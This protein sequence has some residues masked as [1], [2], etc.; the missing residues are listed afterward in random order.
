LE[1]YAKTITANKIEAQ[2]MF[3]DM[4][5]ASRPQKPEPS[6]QAVQLESMAMATE[7]LQ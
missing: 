1:L 4:L 7:V 3:L 5:F 2:G 6:Q